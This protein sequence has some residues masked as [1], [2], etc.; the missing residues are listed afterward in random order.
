ME[1]LLLLSTSFLSATLLPMGSEALLLFYSQDTSLPLFWLWAVASIGNTLGGCVNWWLGV[2]VERFQDRRWF[3]CS[4]KQ[5]VTAK[6]HFAQYGLV[7]LLFSW[8][9]VVGDPLCLIAGTLRT[10]FLR[11]LLLVFIGKAIRY[12]FLLYLVL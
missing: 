5:L 11:F 12:F 2:Y 9:P 7:S 8:L 6:T 3:P 4:Q 10:P 1:Y